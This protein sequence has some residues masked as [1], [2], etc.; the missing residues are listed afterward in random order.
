MTP[1][2]LAEQLACRLQPSGHILEPCAGAGAF[3]RALQ[4]YGQVDWC[5]IDAGRDFFAWRDRVDWIVTNPPWSEFRRFLAHSL[6]LADHVAFIATLNHWFT[7]RR[8][9]MISHAGFGFERLIAFECPPEF[10]P[11]GFQLGMVVLSRHYDGPL[12]IEALEPR[13]L[14]EAQP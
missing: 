5:E 12:S 10:R 6:R 9:H 14:A 3:V 13:L 11:T 4:N 2:W 8:W 1:I 7:R